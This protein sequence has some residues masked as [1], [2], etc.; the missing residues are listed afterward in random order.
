MLGLQYNHINLT[1]TLGMI[2]VLIWIKIQDNVIRWIFQNQSLLINKKKHSKVHQPF[3]KEFSWKLSVVTTENHSI[4]NSSMSFF[5]FMLLCP[6]NATLWQLFA[7]SVTTNGIAGKPMTTNSTPTA[8]WR[9]E[10][11]FR[12]T[13]CWKRASCFWCVVGASFSE[14]IFV[15]MESC[16]MSLIKYLLFGFNLLFAVSYANRKRKRFFT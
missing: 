11:R 7:L 10:I 6:Q 2:L 15:K 16:G 8:G 1:F 14:E 3:C 12:F 5:L 9:G 4:Y 13:L